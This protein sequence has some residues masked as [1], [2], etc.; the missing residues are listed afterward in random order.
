[1]KNLMQFAFW[2]AVGYYAMTKAAPA[3]KAKV[4]AMDIDEVWE[5][6]NEDEAW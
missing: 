4:E 2:F 1:M 6:F 5:I 3:I